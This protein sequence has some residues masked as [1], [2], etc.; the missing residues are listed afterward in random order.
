[1]E[2]KQKELN[3]FAESLKEEEPTIPEAETFAKEE[4]CCEDMASLAETVESSIEAPKSKTDISEEE[5]AFK[6]L[7]G[8]A[9]ENLIK[10]REDWGGRILKLIEREVAFICI[11]I[12]LYVSV[13]IYTRSEITGITT[14]IEIIVAGVLGKTIF[15]GYHIIKG[16]FKDSIHK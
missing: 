5:D 10:L 3:K 11:I 6:K 4:T 1:M 15:L 14:L 2:S 16:I 7:Q 9:L 12:A 13:T 8:N